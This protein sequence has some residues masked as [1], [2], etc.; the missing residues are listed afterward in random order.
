[1][2]RP[3]TVP[4]ILIS[5]RRAPWAVLALLL[6]A[7]N[8]WGIYAL[9][10]SRV[11][12]AVWDFHPRWV[13]LRAMFL[14]GADPYSD[15]VTLAIQQQM[16][17]RPAHPDEDQQ[18]FAYPLHSMV[19]LGPL[20]LL[21]L[22]IAQ[23]VW[24]SLLEAGLLA[25]IV[26][27]PRAVGWRPPT[28]LLAMTA[29]F[30][31]GLYSNVWAL[32]LG[33]TSIV[34]A[35]ILALAWWALRAERWGL[36]GVCLALATIK[37]QMAFLLVPGILAW[38]VYRRR[39]RLVAT[40]AVALGALVL[41][42]VPWLPGWPLE[43]LAAARRYAGYTPF[44]PPLL[45]L[46]RSKWLAAVVAAALLAWTVVRWYRAP[47]P[48][49]AACDWALGMLV[50]TGALVAPRTTHANQLLLLLPLFLVFRRLPGTWAVVAAEIGWLVVPW[51]L[52]LALLPPVSSGLQHTI[53]QNRVISPLL[54]SAL[55]LALLYLSPRAVP[56][57]GGQ[58][59]Q[60]GPP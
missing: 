45:M 33:Q 30:V 9:F 11:Q 57:E 38:A 25:F 29:V 1:M 34:V 46:L 18:A 36:A 13:G 22:P 60:A 55:V 26:L 49:A 7:L 58:F 53:W 19:L 56:G 3:S 39:W 59:A 2:S 17:G 50:V 42:P 21:P 28:W 43:W 31:L 4:T 27:A 10:T 8:A 44:D 20:A 23:A 54:P 41:V 15:E 14:D 48:R 5:L 37:P 35:A 24:F 16:L 51:L 12:V 40:F 32:V 52:D 6:F 47:Q